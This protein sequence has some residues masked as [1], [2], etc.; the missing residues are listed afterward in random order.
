MEEKKLDEFSFKELLGYS[1]E[2]EKAA[3]KFYYDFTEAAIGE[4]VEERFKSLA[5]DEEVHEAALRKR[6]KAEFGEKDYVV[7]DSDKLPPHETS[8]D[9]TSARNII[10]SLEKGM[11]NE[12]NAYRIYK[13]LAKKHEEH[14]DLFEYLAVMEYGHLE[15]LKEEKQMLEGRASSKSDAKDQSPGSFFSFEFEKMQ[16][17]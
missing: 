10:D 16:T 15:S 6:Y 11:E 7:P 9:F 3:Q 13:Y 1:I 2:A 12:R 14:Q 5:K 8:H 4:L 17:Q